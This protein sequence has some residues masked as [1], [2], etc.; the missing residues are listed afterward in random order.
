[1]FR[2]PDFQD[3]PMLTIDQIK[4][5]L[6]NHR[7][8][9]LELDVKRHAA[10]ALIL[11]T[12]EHGTE[13]LLIR[14]A[15]HED[16]PWSGDLAFPGG[17]IED[18]DRDDRAAAE[19]ETWEEIGIDLNHADYLGQGD[20]LG[21]AYLS[22]RVSCFIYHLKQETR[23]TLNNEVVDLFWVP[24]TTLLAPERN[25]MEEFYYRGADREH[26]VIDLSE[27]SQRPLWG[28][29]YRLIDN[30]FQLFGLS[31]KHPEKL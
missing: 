3:N 13:A 11:K 22:V 4:R 9:A 27:W 29:T 19:R 20:D 25:R 18:Q 31:F 1:M 26:P 23:F 10:V 30:F 21:G 12:G 8:K 17:R 7:P 16:D 28:L 2:G 24:L 14:R 15:E 5:R 6:D